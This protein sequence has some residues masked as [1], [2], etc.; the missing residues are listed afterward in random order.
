MNSR[1]HGWAGTDLKPLPLES[2]ASFLLRFAWRNRLSAAQLRECS[3]KS[4]QFP[5]TFDEKIFAQVSSWHSTDIA[6]RHRVGNTHWAV[7]KSDLFRYCP[8]CLECG[9]HSFWHQFSM[10]W[11]CPIHH[12]EL[13]TRCHS[14]NAD[15]PNYPTSKKLFD[16]P[17]YCAKCK[18]PICGVAPSLSAHLDFRECGI[19]LNEAFAP[20]TKWWGAKYKEPKNFHWL[21]LWTGRIEMRMNSCRDQGFMQSILCDGTDVPEYF[22]QPLYRDITTLSWVV[23]PQHDNSSLALFPEQ[24]SW[25]DHRRRALPIYRA[26]LRVLEH[27]IDRHEKPTSAEISRHRSFQVISEGRKRGID[28]RSYQPRLFALCLMR[29]Q[30]EAGFGFGSFTDSCNAEFYYARSIEKHCLNARPLPRLQ[31][32]A[33][34]LAIY[35]VWYYRVLTAKRQGWLNVADL[36]T[37]NKGC[38]VWTEKTAIEHH[39]VVTVGGAVSFPSIHGLGRLVYPKHERSSHWRFSARRN[40]CDLDS[41]FI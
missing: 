9:Y 13:R 31:W 17:Y 3:S 2:C 25:N 20:Y 19:D 37:T 6:E 18:M 29:W 36:S 21:N 16:R 41:R 40:C 26:T 35:A 8:L 34:Y 22:S 14:C 4:Q 1:V 15:C 10:L 30:L 27:Q 11:L 39:L 33:I 7:W 12:I 32:R 38:I 5:F 24:Y 23:L 28:V